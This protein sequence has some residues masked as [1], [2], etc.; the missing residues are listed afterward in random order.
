MKIYPQKDI[1]AVIGQMHEL[2]EYSETMHE[3]TGEY[4]AGLENVSYLL[5]GGR[6]AQS[7]VKGAERGQLPVGRILS[8]EDKHEAARMIREIAG[9]NSLVVIKASRSE[10]LE[11]IVEY[12]RK[13]T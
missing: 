6:Y 10:R 7:V 8:F 5:A 9:D 3:D 13:E 12:I 11:D 2:G 4:I 1:I